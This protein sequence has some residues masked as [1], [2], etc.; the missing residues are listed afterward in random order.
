MSPKAHLVTSNETW[1]VTPKP[2][3]PHLQKSRKTN[4]IR[5]C[6]L[7]NTNDPKSLNLYIFS[8][9]EFITRYCTRM[10]DHETLLNGISLSNSFTKDSEN[11][12][13]GGRNICKNQ[14]GWKT[15]RRQ[16]HLDTKGQM[17]IC[18]NTYVTT[19]MGPS[20]GQAR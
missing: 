1:G 6:P 3:L 12:S 13:R 18:M 11:Y 15:P 17:Y 14:W 4:N 8:S 19:C 9:C 20:Q 16:C 5:L 7:W 2:L 10:R